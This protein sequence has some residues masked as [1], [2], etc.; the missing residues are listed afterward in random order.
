MPIERTSAGSPQGV[1]H[2]LRPSTLS[3]ASIGVRPAAV[4]RKRCARSVPTSSPSGVGARHVA[5]GPSI[6]ARVVQTPLRCSSSVEPSTTAHVV[7]P[8]SASAVTDRPVSGSTARA[9]SP[10]SVQRPPAV[11]MKMFGSMS[12]DTLGRHEPMKTDLLLIPMSARWA[13]MRAAALAAEAA[14]FDG[15]W[16][17]DHLRDPD[18]NDGGPGVPEAWTVL[19]ALAEVT[20]RVALG[21]LVLNVANRVPGVLANMAATLQAVSGGRLLLGLGAGGHRR[22]PYAAEQAAIGQRVN[23]DV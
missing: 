21:P 4:R 5:D 1:Y 17:W 11:P 19:T 9:V 6:A 10:S 20:T 7:T 12:N 13:E 23:T 22:T 14:G 16:T 15:L 3:N 18:G 8:S 2:A